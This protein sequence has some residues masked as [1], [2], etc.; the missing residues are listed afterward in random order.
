MADIQ[1]QMKNI[2]ELVNMANN[3]LTDIETVLLQAGETY[4][5]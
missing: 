1:L 2:I 4:R 3:Q 5:M